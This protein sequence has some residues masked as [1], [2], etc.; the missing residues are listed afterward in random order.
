MASLPPSNS[1]STFTSFGSSHTRYTAPNGQTM[2]TSE[3]WPPQTTSAPVAFQAQSSTA[4]ALPFP[5]PGGS[6]SS[7]IPSFPGI[8]GTP[9]GSQF[10]IPYPTPT[11]APYPFPSPTP[12]PY[13][14]TPAPTPSSGDGINKQ[15]LVQLLS[16]MVQ[17]MSNMANQLK[18]LIM[19]MMQQSQ[20]QQN[21]YAVLGTQAGMSGPLS[22][23]PLAGSLNPGNPLAGN[24]LLLA[25]L[26]GQ[27]K[28]QPAAG[29]GSNLSSNGLSIGALQ[30][31]LAQRQ[32]QSQLGSN[33]L[34]QL[35][36]QQQQPSALG[37]NPLAQLLGQQQPGNS[38]LQPQLLT[39]NTALAQLLAQRQQQGLGATGGLGSLGASG[40]GLGG[41]T[42]GLPTG[43]LGSSGPM[44]LGSLTGL[45][46]T[47]GIGALGAGMGGGTQGSLLNSP[48]IGSAVNS[49]G[50]GGQL[51][52][53]GGLLG[54][55]GA[56]SNGL[57][58]LLS[59]GNNEIAI[60]LNGLLV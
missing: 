5:F 38:L 29:L 60:P 13:P 17:L 39:S 37:S 43:I 28:Q 40:G 46:A 34:A 47:S 59:T 36:D 41:I 45:G 22:G 58:S 9:T 24:P 48:G 35:L 12:F 31:L 55:T 56:S 21:P 1:F 19:M 7:S 11:P 26:L 51:D 42:S 44:S 14:T 2:E 30:Q 52:N 32:Q 53:L 25:Q 8:P 33:P 16:G 18:L 27:Q 54:L 50:L 57:N 4:G 10:P 23:N 6:G 49:L 15:Q 20:Q 3:V